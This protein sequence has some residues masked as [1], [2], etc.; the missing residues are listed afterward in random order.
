MKNE[1]INSQ[2]YSDETSIVITN[3]EREYDDSA[4]NQFC[5]LEDLQQMAKK[6][7]PLAIYEYIASG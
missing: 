5:N 3:D 1:R 2:R 7:L 6:K 4:S